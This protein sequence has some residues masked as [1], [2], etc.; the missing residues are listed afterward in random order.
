MTIKEKLIYKVS[1]DK[2]VIFLLPFILIFISLIGY[3]LT[4]TLIISVGIFLL[5][6]I[7]YI[8][9]LNYFEFKE[10]K[11]YVRNIFGL[12]EKN[13]SYKR[14]NTVTIYNKGELRFSRALIIINYDNNRKLKMKL[15]K[16]LGLRELLY[17]FKS[18]GIN[19]LIETD[20]E[21]DIINSEFKEFL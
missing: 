20:S 11:L 3:F 9:N 13:I 10:T 17:F 2:E 7:V 1:L 14:L 8:F 15:Q 18:R 5:G 21:T 19:V 4:D 12:N 16:K 6:I